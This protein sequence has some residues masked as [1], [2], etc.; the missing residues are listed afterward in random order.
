M[1]D[2]VVARRED[3]SH[4]REDELVRRKLTKQEKKERGWSATFL[5]AT[6]VKS[7]L[8]ADA[9]EHSRK[10][11]RAG[12]LTGALHYNAVSTEPPARH[13]SKR[14]VVVQRDLTPDAKITN[15]PVPPKGPVE[16]QPERC[17]LKGALQGS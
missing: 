2:G 15:S 12:S 4:R 6:Q 5:N 1:I 3:R 11:A 9:S 8:A 17:S 14:V 10:R 7:S 13:Q 16:T